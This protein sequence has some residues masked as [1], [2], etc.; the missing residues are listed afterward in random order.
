MPNPV[1]I[2]I[3]AETAA[4]QTAFQQLTNQYVTGLKTLETQS[5]YTAQSLLTTGEAATQIAQRLRAA[6]QINDVYFGNQ[7]AA[8]AA[9]FDRI[10]AASTKSAGLT[11]GSLKGMQRAVS[12][13]AGN[14]ALN[15]SFLAGPGAT[16]FVYPIVLAGKE[17]KG[18][19]SALKLTGTLGLSTAA[20]TG[21]LGAGIVALAGIVATATEGWKAYKASVQAAAAEQAALTQQFD[22]RA[23][24]IK[25][26]NENS[27]RLNPGQADDLKKQLRSASDSELRSVLTIVREKLKAVLVTKEQWEAEERL[28]E[29]LREQQDQ[30]LTGFARER[31]EAE[32]AYF[33]K[34]KEIEAEAKLRG[35]IKLASGNTSTPQ[36]A[37]QAA[38]EAHALKMADINRRERAETEAARQAIV[39]GVADEEEA[40]FRGNELYAKR[41]A[42]RQLNQLDTDFTLRELDLA[43]SAGPEARIALANEEF[44]ARQKLYDDLVAKG[45]FTED[46]LTEAMSQAEIRRTQI[47]RA[48]EQA[49]I[50]L[51]RQTQDAAVDLLGSAAAAAQLFGRKGF[52]AFKSLSIAQATVHAILATMRALSDVPYPANLVVAAAAAAA[53]AVNVAQIA[54]TQ[55]AGFQQGGFTGTGRNDEP[56]GIVHRNEWVMPANVVA[57]EGP[58]RLAAFQRGESATGG[59]GGSVNQITVVPVVD[60]HLAWQLYADNVDAMIVEAF[61]RRGL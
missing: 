58:A 3:T 11:T 60:K 10:S 18:L 1:V 24:L 50:Q 25:L 52:A 51:H 45:V 38:A 2:T 16:Q 5:R 36:L 55:P 22:Q 49:R 56:A 7:G 43:P 15:A 17:L 47:V 42:Q 9:S 59:G 37:Y 26:L 53:G 35:N 6:G 4:A 21:V 44:T 20:A 28:G 27:K 40:I 19:H 61:K 32:R 54:S 31:Q 33:A 39:K 23:R 8:V 46:Q 57:R 48:E 29:I 14:L 13:F 34:K 12:G 30:A 41:Q